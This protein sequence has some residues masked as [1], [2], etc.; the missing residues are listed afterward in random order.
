MAV[1]AGSKRSVELLQRAVNKQVEP[2]LT[3]D[4]S[5]GPLTRAAL[6]RLA[7]L[8]VLRELCADLLLERQAHYS[9]LCAR[10][11]EQVKFLRGWLKRALE[12]RALCDELG[13]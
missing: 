2:P 10:D 1:N 9:N 12:L 11:R 8:G 6:R 5:L 13:G 3:V 7:T 4:G